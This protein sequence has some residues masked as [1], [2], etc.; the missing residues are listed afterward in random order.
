MADPRN[1]LETS[2]STRRGS[3]SEQKLVGAGL[4]SSK[5]P[6][7]GDTEKEGVERGQSLR[8]G[9]SHKLPAKVHLL[10]VTDYLGRQG[11]PVVE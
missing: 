11:L 9:R 7:L 4:S 5:P 1:S 6:G 8:S 2:A 10:M 3:H